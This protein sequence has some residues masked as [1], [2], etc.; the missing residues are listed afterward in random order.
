MRSER[1]FAFGF[2]G[3]LL[4][5]LFQMAEVLSPF[6]RPL[7]WAVILAHVTFPLHTRLTSLL[8]GCEGASA[9]LL[10][11]GSVALIVAPVVYFTF[12]LV[13]EAGNCY[14]PVNTWVQSGG[15]TRLPHELAKLPLMG[16]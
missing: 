10:T 6:L 12:L 2:L 13:Q 11:V 14:D 3:V 8:R 4:V 15:A 16:R 9:A 1:L 7:L 5:L